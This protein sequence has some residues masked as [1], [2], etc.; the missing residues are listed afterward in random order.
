MY[1]TRHTTR[2]MHCA[3]SQVI[4]HLQQPQVAQCASRNRRIIRAGFSVGSLRVLH[5]LAVSVAV[6]VATRWLGRHCVHRGGQHQRYGGAIDRL[7]RPG[8]FWVRIAAEAEHTGRS[9][10]ARI[11]PSFCPSH[12]TPGLTTPTKKALRTEVGVCEVIVALARCGLILRSTRTM[13]PN[14][15]E[16]VIFLKL[17]ICMRGTPRRGLVPAHAGLL[18]CLISTCFA[19]PGPAVGLRHHDGESVVSRGTL[20]MYNTWLGVFTAC[21]C[22]GR[23]REMPCRCRR[24]KITAA[25]ARCTVPAELVVLLD[26]SA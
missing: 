3:T 21:C 5:S 15:H 9:T 7:R 4:T 26:Q 11:H 24:R 1:H 8:T 16:S 13:S 17:T 23:C 12:A 14:M 10:P 19:K 20:S 2:P 25:R 6:P 22:V 18:P